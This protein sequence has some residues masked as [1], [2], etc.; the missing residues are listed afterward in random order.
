MVVIVRCP[1]VRAARKVRVSV[2]VLARGRDVMGVPIVH[3]SVVAFVAMLMVVGVLVPMRVGMAM[4]DVPMRMRVVVNVLVRMRV[5][6]GM[7]RYGVEC[8]RH[9]GLAG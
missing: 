2:I 4:R 5:L 7:R 6:V 9:G 3:G 1:F 8:D